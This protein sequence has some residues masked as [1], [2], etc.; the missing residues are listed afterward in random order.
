MQ[1]D[2][3]TL[4]LQTIN[5][6]VVVWLLSRFLYRPVRRMIEEREAA[7]RKA[8][9]AAEEKARKAE[10]ARADYET[11]R[12]ELD[13]TYRKREAELHAAA[14][15]E[16]NAMLE[17]AQNEA[18]AL[19][20][21][22]RDRIARERREALEALQARIAGL[23]ADLAKTALKGQAPSATAE[24]ERVAAFLDGLS[25][26]ERE[27][28]RRDLSADRGAVTVTTAAA[29]PEDLRTAWRA[30]LSQRL[31]DDLRVEF[32]EDPAILGGVELHLPHG[33]LRFSVA[34]RLNRAAAAMK[35]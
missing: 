10:E 29:P 30:A 14:A 33:A 13:E 34:D 35:D 15:K 11:R 4:A 6:L 23:A 27:E 9:E 24:V 32:I 8:A 16:R 28:L 5:F 20:A 22:A 21:E 25:G 19:I 2:W 3:W 26:A 18:D 12:A 7:D 31:G 17:A 1:I